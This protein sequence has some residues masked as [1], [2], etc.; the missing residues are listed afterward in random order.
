MFGA[1]ALW[2]AFSQLRGGAR[3]LLRNRVRVAAS[4]AAKLPV[5]AAE[6]LERRFGLVVAEGYGL[7]EASPVVTSS[8][9]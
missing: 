1:P 7:T 8:T 2:V 3:R 4:G 9:G 5:S 6:A